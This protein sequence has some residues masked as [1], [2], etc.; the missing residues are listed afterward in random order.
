MFIE[1][2][3]GNTLESVENQVSEFISN[4]KKTATFIKMSAPYINRNKNMPY[5]IN[6]TYDTR[7]YQ[8]KTK[9]N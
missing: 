3:V 9:F 8:I 4:I 6:V 5:Q 7:D 1:P 2:F